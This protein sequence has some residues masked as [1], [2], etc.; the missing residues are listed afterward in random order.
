MPETNEQR[1]F[2]E[3][4]GISYFRSENVKVFPC[5]Y[6]GYRRLV[7]NNA[8]NTSHVVYNPESRGFTEYNYSHVYPR[9]DK[10]NGSYLV[11][12]EN[13]NQSNGKLCCVIGGYYFEL[14]NV[15]LSDLADKRLAIKVTSISLSEN[16]NSSNNP[17]ETTYILAA[18][19]DQTA[20]VLDTDLLN[21]GNSAFIGLAVLE[22]TQS[23]VGTIYA[24]LSLVEDIPG[25]NDTHTY[26][27]KEEAKRLD[28]VLTS[29]SGIGSIQSRNG[30][31]NCVASGDY[32]VSLG[33]KNTVSGE[34]SIAIGSNNTVSGSV[35]GAFG[36]TNT[37]SKGFA[38][39]SHL[40]AV[41][42]NQLV[43]GSYNQS[44]AGYALIIG[45]GTNA[46]AKNNILTVGKET[47]AI[48]T[49]GNISADGNLTIK[50]NA[51]INQDLEVNGDT[52]QAAKLF[53]TPSQENFL[54]LGSTIANDSGHIIVYGE[55]ADIEAVEGE[56]YTQAEI[57]IAHEGDDAYGKT[58]DDWKVEPVEAQDSIVFEVTNTGATT[59]DETLTTK[60]YAVIENKT[61]GEQTVIP[62]L[63]VQGRIVAKNGLDNTLVLGSATAGDYG[64]INI[65]GA[66]KDIVF[67]VE[68]TGAITTA[69]NLTVRDRLFVKGGLECSGFYKPIEASTFNDRNEY[70]GKYLR[71][72]VNGQET[73]VLITADN[74]NEEISVVNNEL[75][76]V[77]AWEKLDNK[78]N[79]SLK[80]TENISTGGTA[81]IT[82]DTTVE[83]GNLK[84]S[85]GKLDVKLGITGNRFVLDAPD[86]YT[87]ETE[88]TEEDENAPKERRAFLLQKDNAE[89]FSIDT[90]GNVNSVGGA[91]FASGITAT[92][93]LGIG[94]IITNNISITKPYTDSNRFDGIKD[95][96]GISSN[97]TTLADTLVIGNTQTDYYG[98]LP[99]NLHIAKGSLSC[100][101]NFFVA[102]QSEDKSRA[103]ITSSGAAWFAQKL[104][105][106]DSFVE[107]GEDGNWFFLVGSSAGT[108]FAKLKGNFEG[109]GNLT[110][111]GTGAID[112]KVT[113]GHEGTEPGFEVWGNTNLHGPVTTTGKVT[114]SSFYATSDI[115]LKQNISDYSCEKSIL[116]LP[117]KEFEYIN[118]E[119]HTKHI[120]CIAQDLQQICPEL[121][122]KNDAGYLTIEE[123][124]LVY[125]L[126]DE[127]KKLRNEV[128]E[129]K[130]E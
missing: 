66:D 103:I 116:D 26:K 36:D 87:E 6:R 1:I 86:F 34:S 72:V 63:T 85:A 101:G 24:E 82:G 18:F 15:Q 32:S 31:N 5:A 23:N 79:G 11:S 94:D 77:T 120:G 13:S 42:D 64:A 91:T 62:G 111:T 55:A 52:I 49:Q 65:Y 102:S 89:L 71:K 78:I 51:I 80:I 104:I 68:K 38:F 35:S 73:Y 59:I 12:W 28:D 16:T 98:Q 7:D 25:D 122:Q 84:V 97:Y 81:T 96:S 67:K 130:G 93:N 44:D 33:K 37:V 118:D 112:G 29:G 100:R 47:G 88:E 40:T 128:K 105:V 14:Y 45:N 53:D 114:A 19:K 2:I 58:T 46:E 108:N 109:T 127:V 60:N 99:A 21:N 39:G 107:A 90:A 106:G 76:K 125:L 9:L 124:K 69:D 110:I 56:H 95:W 22:K 54:K 129:L 8:A 92:G 115:C 117:I 30:S 74:V 70:I 4:E 43:I 75:Q 119:A 48:T 27:L 123:S 57:D 83:E 50:G 126:L 61:I 3:S 10:E 113:I 20:T 41:G 17:L 121:V